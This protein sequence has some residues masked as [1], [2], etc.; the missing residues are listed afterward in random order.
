MKMAVPPGK[1]FVD[2]YTKFVPKHRFGDVEALH[3][4]GRVR[5]V[6]EPF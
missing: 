6:L 5:E 4:D 1:Q 3:I 2:Y